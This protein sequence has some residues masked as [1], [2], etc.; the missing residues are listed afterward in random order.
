MRVFLLLSS[1]GGVLL[2]EL[3]STGSL[4]S[5]FCKTMMCIMF[6][7]TGRVGLGRQRP[8]CFC[9]FSFIV[10]VRMGEGSFQQGACFLE[11]TKL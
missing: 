7:F 9:L 11:G 10:L 6:L 2:G 4:Q 8:E 5:R 3:F 1:C